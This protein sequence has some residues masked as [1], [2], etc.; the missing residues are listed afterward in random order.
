MTSNISD[1]KEMIAMLGLTQNTSFSAL[2]NCFIDWSSSLTIQAIYDS[3]LPKFNSLLKEVNILQSFPTH[4]AKTFS[5]LESILN[6]LPPPLQTFH[7]TLPLSLSLDHI[8]TQEELSKS[9]NTTVVEIISPLINDIP[10]RMNPSLNKIMTL[11]SIESPLFQ[12]FL[13]KEEFSHFVK[14]C[15][16]N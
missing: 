7:H 11:L 15:M 12:N 8:I 2:N 16:T 4:F 10:L 5:L 3:L 6:Y 13:D 1:V 14:R 9:L